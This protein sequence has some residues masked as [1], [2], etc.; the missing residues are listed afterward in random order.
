MKDTNTVATDWEIKF[1][2]RHLFHGVIYHKDKYFGYKLR[3]RD[4][5]NL[6]AQYVNKLNTLFFSVETYFSAYL[7]DIHA[8]KSIDTS[9]VPKIKDY[10]NLGKLP[11]PSDDELRLL[12]KTLLAWLYEEG[13]F[14]TFDRKDKEFDSIEEQYDNE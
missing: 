1:L 8:N 4:N 13:Y 3:G 2:P 11:L 6:K 5:A 10:D 12:E 9:N 7:N 14:R